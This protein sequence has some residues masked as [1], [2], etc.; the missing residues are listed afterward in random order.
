MNLPTVQFPEVDNYFRVPGA[1]IPPG[2]LTSSP[3][4][5]GVENPFYGVPPGQLKTQATVNGVANPFYEQTPG[6]WVV[7][8]GQFPPES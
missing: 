4:I 2:Q 7:P 6:H 8:D 1:H 3:V 5:N